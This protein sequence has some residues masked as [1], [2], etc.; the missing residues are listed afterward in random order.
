MIFP[1][2]SPAILLTLAFLMLA[3]AFIVWKWPDTR[4]LEGAPRG[5]NRR[6]NVR[7]SPR[8]KDR[9]QAL[10]EKFRDTVTFYYS[11][12]DGKYRIG[13]GEKRFDLKWGKHG[14][15]SVYLYNDPG[16]IR[17]IA[18]ADKLSI[19]EIEDASSYNISSRVCVVG[20][21]EIAVLQ[22]AHGYWAA[23]RIIDIEGDEITFEYVIQADGTP[24]FRTCRRSCSTSRMGP[25]R[26]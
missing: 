16:N 11:N 19:D 14:E 9:L 15:G 12:D 18:V 13:E 20:I 8:P 7:S 21:G 23:A 10:S 1:D 24:N 3:T 5:A 22:N 25:P 17:A 2:A 6:R 26:P 4:K